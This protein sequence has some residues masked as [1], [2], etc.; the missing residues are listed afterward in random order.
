MVDG[1]SYGAVL[2][3]P[4][5]LRKEMASVKV[6]L[7]FQSQLVLLNSSK[8]LLTGFLHLRSPTGTSIS[9]SYWKIDPFIDDFPSYQPA[10][11]EDFP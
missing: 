8:M 1:K 9:H 11:I 5:S 7:A 10:F 6:C 2:C 4:W 3:Q